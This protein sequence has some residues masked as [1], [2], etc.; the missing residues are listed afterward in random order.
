MMRKLA[1]A[2]ALA[3]SL[4]TLSVLALP[5]SADAR[6]FFFPHRM[7]GGVFMHGPIMHGAMMNGPFFHRPEIFSGPRI[8]MMRME[9]RRFFRPHIFFGPQILY[10]AYD[11][12]YDTYPYYSNGCYWLKVRAIRT[13]SRYWWNRYAICRADN[14]Y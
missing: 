8:G 6:P 3:L 5:N 9:H 10:G 7:G 1:M 12:N 4:C 14:G 2:L 11:Y 13:H